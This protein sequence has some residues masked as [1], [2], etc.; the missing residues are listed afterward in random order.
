MTLLSPTLP[1]YVPRFNRDKPIIAVVGENHFTELTDYVVPYGVLSESGVAQVFALSTQAG[2]I[3]MFPAL[4]V[5]PQATITEFD[6]QFPEGADYVVVPAVFRSKKPILL[7]W[8]NHQARR[9]ATIIGICDGVWVLANAGLLEGQQGVGHWFS[10]K[11][12]EKKFPKTKWLKNTRYVGSG[13]VITTTGVSASIPVSVALTEAIAGRDRAMEL[14][15]RIG[16]QSW[17]I[18]HQ[19]KQFKLKVSH[20]FTAIINRLSFWLNENVGISIN[21][22][23]DEI[24]LALLVDAYSRSFRSKAILLAPHNRQMLSKHGL[25][26]QPHESQPKDNKIDREIELQSDLPSIQSFNA[27]L[28]EIGQLYGPATA[29]FIALQ[30]EYPFRFV[31]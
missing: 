3:R 15:Q 29:S 10:M 12:L 9:G 28:Q 18:D 16:I 19:S 30:L 7:A 8:I 6:R 5:I 4:Q 24:L 14:A 31:A 27:A 2:P 26:I 17:E 22:E 13:N 20:I 11:R 25:I 21:D 1:S 23:F